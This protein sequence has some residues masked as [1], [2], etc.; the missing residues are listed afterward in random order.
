MVV[1]DL[2]RELSYVKDL[3]GDHGVEEF[4][5]STTKGEE[6]TV[7]IL[8]PS[9]STTVPGVEFVEDPNNLL[10]DVLDA[11]DESFNANWDDIEDRLSKLKKFS[12][13]EKKRDFENQVER[14]QA[15]TRV[16]QTKEKIV[17]NPRNKYVRELIKR[18]SVKT[19]KDG[20]EVL[21]LRSELGIKKSGTQI[22]KRG[23]TSMLGY[24]KNSPA[25]SEYKELV[26]KIGMEQTA[27]ETT[28]QGP[29]LSNFD[30]DQGGTEEFE[31]V[32]VNKPMDNIPGLTEKENDELRGVLNPGESADLRAWVGTNGA[33]ELQAAYFQ[34]ALK[35]T[36]QIQL[37]LLQEETS[38]LVGK[39]SAE[40]NK[41]IK[42]E[43]AVDIEAL[44]IARSRVFNGNPVRPSWLEL[45]HINEGVVRRYT[46]FTER[47]DALED[48]RDR[49][50]EQKTLEEVKVEQLNDISRLR[51]F[52]KWLGKEKV[53]LAGVAVSAAGLITTLLIH[54]R[55]AIVG[56]AKATG[57]VAKALANIAKKGAPILVPVLNAIA[58]ALLWG[59]KGI[60]WL[61]SHLWV[62]A[63]AAVLMVYNYYTK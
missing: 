34:E 21:M 1:T 36:E 12:T 50:I 49:T 40:P 46:E 55:G 23:K 56:T 48:A 27:E 19:L 61:V 11:F 51:R 8:G 15:V 53:A 30:N 42:G 32:D 38:R 44:R 43:L 5:A 47:I 33:L 13:A 62:L 10:P 3:M 14:V 31:L 57:R 20:T 52:T 26:K 25:L 41:V 45:E 18:S 6:G 24:S 28:D 7:N 22:M 4:L 17:L 35:E 63:I 60:A 16:I 59:A 58:T 54:A 2:N 9:G 39:Y 29:E 37:D